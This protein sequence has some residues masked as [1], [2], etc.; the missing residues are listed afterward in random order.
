MVHATHNLIVDSNVAYN[1]SGH[2]FLVEEG[3]EQ[4]NLF[5]NNLGFLTVAVD[6]RISTQESDHDPSTFWISNIKNDYIGNVAA[7]S[8]S[9]G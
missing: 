8:A 3:G 4:D 5:R 9:S 1:T 2:C 6:R 7:G